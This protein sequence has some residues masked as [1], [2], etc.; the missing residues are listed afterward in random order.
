MRKLILIAVTAASA[1]GLMACTPTV[2]L[3]V[4][5]S[6]IYAKLDVNVRVQLD[7]DVKAL[8]QQNPNLF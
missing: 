6:P 1:A 5:M 8:V 2:N 3:N 7:E 4:N